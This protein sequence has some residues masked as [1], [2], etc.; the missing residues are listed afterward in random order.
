[1]GGILTDF[2]SLREL[3]AGSQ[4]PSGLVKGRQ[5]RGLGSEREKVSGWTTGGRGGALEQLGFRG[6]VIIL[7]LQ[8][9]LSGEK[10]ILVNPQTSSRKIHKELKDMIPF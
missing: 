1:M 9:S 8:C 7:K 2:W 4:E 3:G 5:E 6:L 10:D